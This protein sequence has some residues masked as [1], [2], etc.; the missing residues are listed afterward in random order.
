MSSAFV[1]SLLALWL[2]GFDAAVSSARNYHSA[3]DV[4]GALNSDGE[5][6]GC[7]SRGDKGV[8]EPLCPVMATSI[9]R[10]DLGAVAASPGTFVF[11]ERAREPGCARPITVTRSSI[12]NTTSP[13]DVLLNASER[14]DVLPDVAL[15]ERLE[16]CVP[17]HE[18]GPPPDAD[19]VDAC[20]VRILIAFE[21]TSEV[22][23]ATR[24]RTARNAVLRAVTIAW[25]APATVAILIGLFG[26]DASASYDEFLSCTLVL[27]KVHLDVNLYF[28]LRRPDGG[29]WT[30]TTCGI[31][32]HSAWWASRTVAGAI[33]HTMA[34]PTCP[35]GPDSASTNS[36][37]PRFDTLDT[38]LADVGPN[39]TRVDVTGSRYV[40]C[41][42][43]TLRLRSAPRSLWRSVS[44]Q[45]AIC[46]H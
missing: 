7:A 19:S 14:L 42:R 33:V 28:R 44:A 45:C 1:P 29:E 12:G 10:G 35:S 4:C 16:E 36:A 30:C 3:D 6:A 41:P 23:A 20:R 46:C 8:F 13:R 22:L 17:K 32:R 26:C 34:Q 40:L 43:L 5:A 15:P 39:G 18:M 25:G 2:L 27:E 11:R 24:T 9:S 38:P 21:R 37:W 31:H